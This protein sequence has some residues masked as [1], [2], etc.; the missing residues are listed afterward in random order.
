VTDP[1]DVLPAFERRLK[2]VNVENT[3][4]SAIHL[5]RVAYPTISPLFVSGS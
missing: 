4:R 5:F 1:T 2:A 3:R